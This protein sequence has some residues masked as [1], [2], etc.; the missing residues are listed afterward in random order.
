VTARIFAKLL[1]GAVVLLVVAMAVVGFFANRVMESSYVQNLTVHLAEN[2]RLIALAGAVDAADSPEARML[3]MAHDTGSRLTVIKRDGQVVIDSDAQ[4]SR[5]ENH[6]HRPEFVAALAG[7]IGSSE[8][9]SATTGENYL[10]VAIPTADGALRLARP[11]SV[12][13]SQVAAIRSKMLTGTV[14][15]FLPAIVIAAFFAR[16]ISKRLAAIIAFAGE[17]AKGNYRARLDSARSGELGILSSQ[18]KEA[19]ENLQRAVE[20]LDREHV[21]LEKLERIR[22]DFVINV[23]HE[24]RT[25]LA[26]IQGYA[27]TLMDGALEDHDNNMRFLAVIRQNAERLASLTA[28]LLTLSRIEMRRQELNYAPYK[29]SELLTEVM[30][31]VFPIARK[32][33]IRLE[34]KLAPEVDTVYCDAEAVHQILINLLDN[35]MKY[36]PDGGVITLGTR[37]HGERE[38]E[39]FVKDSGVGIPAEDVPRLFERFYRVDKARSRELG[40]TGLGL[41]IVKHLVLAQN[42]EVHVESVLNEGST[43]SFTLPVDAPVKPREVHPQFTTS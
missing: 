9:R 18:L 39:I 31:T 20:Q 33:Q 19:G 4:P 7:K 21:E 11:L 28:D 3:K 41:A 43:F 10:Y 29:A 34:Q 22:K 30:E 26:S 8:R 12:I 24:L 25:P 27:E 40:G 15:A 23:S 5:M 42:G 2:A 36:T 16:R 14:V 38:V 17:L 37:P 32:K 35:A 1:A 13:D 6:A